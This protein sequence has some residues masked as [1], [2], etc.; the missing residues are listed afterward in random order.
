[1]LRPLL[2]LAAAI[3]L[4]G[5]RLVAQ[6]NERRYDVFVVGVRVAEL[7]I[8]DPPA[9]G[10]SSI[11]KK[12][13]ASN[14]WSSARTAPRSA[15]GSDTAFRLWGAIRDVP[16]TLASI[17]RIDWDAHDLIAWP[18]RASVYERVR[19][20]EAQVGSARR[21]GIRWNKQDASR[22]MDLI[23]GTDNT[24]IAAIDPRAD[25]VMV[26]RGYEAFTTVGAWNRPDVSQAR[27][28]YRALGR[29]MIPMADGVRLATLV[30]L[31]DEGATGPFPTIFV[32][33]PYGI[34]G[35]IDTYWHYAARGFAVVLQAA[36]GTS[37]TDPANMSEGELELMVNEPR[38]GKAALEWVTKQ[39]WSDGKICMQGGSYVAYTQWTAA[40]SG[41]PALRCLVP[42]SSMG[43]AFADQ[44]YVGGG[45][46][47]GM[48]YY[49][50]FMHN[51]KLLPGRTW[52]EV[53]AHRPILDL[54]VFATGGNIP[55]WDKQVLNARNDAYWQGQNWHQA[56][57]RPDLGTL[58]IS[59]WFD[60]DLPGTLSNWSLMQRIGSAPQR[61]LLGPW[62]HGYNADRM[63][64]GYRYGLDALRDDVWLIKQQWYDHFLKGIDNAV[65]RTR[66]E[67]FVLGDNAWRT[68]SAWPPKEVE[69][70]SW[71][72]HGDGQANRLFTAGTLDRRAPSGDE[73]PE[74]YRYDPKNPPPNWMSFEQMERW[75]DVQTFQWDMKD[76]E[77]RHDVV[78]FTSA[79]LERDLTIAGDILAVLYA[80]TDVAD[81]DWWVHVSDVDPAG[82]SNRL[83]LGSIRARF[84]NL[85]DPRFRGRGSNFEREELLSGNPAEVVK[86]EI[87][88][89]GVANTFKRG[90]RIRVAV[91]NALDNY[92]FP[93]SNTGGDEARVTE[94]VV[95]SMAIHHTRLHPSHIVLPGLPP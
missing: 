9:V 41:D 88:V 93:N 42:E 28:G 44:P 37:Y 27:Y 4:S 52:T 82:R 90:H 85:E 45:M 95:G 94:T 77:A 76:I 65:T 66:V 69:L 30:Y 32:R 63:L 31:P 12:G 64:N 14:R 35:L 18:N 5:V 1:M 23:L 80:S 25:I 3:A 50:L 10:L 71:Y 49:T 47:V 15:V 75:E 83:T 33:T 59:G 89:R 17:E 79:P 70:Q 40:M 22:P 6:S 58:Q 72:F 2:V 67:Y 29:Q 8:N 48:A 16:A 91:M 26:R 68:A 19:G 36:R 7:T 61:L 84:R 73:P 54:D 24:L 38:D 13:M 46:L 11:R 34:S 39:P 43:T 92:T 57:I 56:P 81:T 60:D 87:G 86:L 78:T 53:L 51:R 62:K 74:R 20:V 21:T 55:N